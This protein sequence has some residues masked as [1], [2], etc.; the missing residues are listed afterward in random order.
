MPTERTVEK[1]TTR[2]SFDPGM[3]PDGAPTQDDIDQAIRAARH[4][5][6]IEG[7][8]GTNFARAQALLARAQAIKAQADAACQAHGN[9]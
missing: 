1:P 6:R 4:K 9:R 7:R 3:L 8:H 2:R 5:V